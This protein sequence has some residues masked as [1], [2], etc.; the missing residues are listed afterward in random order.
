[1]IK[2]FFD[3]ACPWIIEGTTLAVVMAYYNNRKKK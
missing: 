3:A 1:M 2:D